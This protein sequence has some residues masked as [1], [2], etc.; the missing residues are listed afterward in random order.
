MNKL[1]LL[2]IFVVFTNVIS[3][4]T[5]LTI[6]YKNGKIKGSKEEYLKTNSVAKWAGKFSIDEFTISDSITYYQTVESFEEKDEF[7]IKG[8]KKSRNNKP[9]GKNFV[10]GANYCNYASGFNIQAIEW[11]DNNYL[12]KTPVA[13][14]Q[15]I[16]N[17]SEEKKVVLGYNCSKATKLN[18][19]NEV[20]LIVWYFTDFK[21]TYSSDGDSS[22][23]GIILES[24]YPKTNTLITAID[25]QI[26]TNIIMT[27]TAKLGT[28]VSQIDFEKIK[29]NK[30]S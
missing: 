15:K 28:L 21:C 26:E 11:K 5:K 2:L 19:N 27:P 9:L 18:D 20:E 25:L 30:K 1:K 29:K 12:V 8:I 10:L 3:A 24:Y 6:L 13:D 17:T 16:W 23:P 4:Q 22:L 7:T 14:K